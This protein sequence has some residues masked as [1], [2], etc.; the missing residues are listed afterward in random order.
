MLRCRWSLYYTADDQSNSAACPSLET[1]GSETG[2]PLHNVFTLVLG[3]EGTLVT[4]DVCQVSA[5][6]HATFSRIP[7]SHI[8]AL[9]S[10]MHLMLTYKRMHAEMM[11]LTYAASNLLLCRL[12]HIEVPQENGDFVREISVSKVTLTRAYPIAPDQQRKHCVK[13]R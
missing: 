1:D 9:I 5:H 8:H 11:C 12:Q 7:E 4:L 3:E 6:P 10:H 13:S 2:L